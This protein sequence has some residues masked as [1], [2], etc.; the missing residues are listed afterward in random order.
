MLLTV[1][2]ARRLQQGGGLYLNGAAVTD[3]KATLSTSNLLDGR[4]VVMRAGKHNR[5]ILVLA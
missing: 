3:A 2:E 5:K 1:G 4:F